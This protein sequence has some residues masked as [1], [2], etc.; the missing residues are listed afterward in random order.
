MKSNY[1]YQRID[2]I[3]V[4]MAQR[5][6]LL[7]IANVIHSSTDTKSH[8]ITNTM[9]LEEEPT[10]G[11][12]FP[13]NPETGGRIPTPSDAVFVCDSN[14]GGAYNPQNY[15]PPCP[16]GPYQNCEKGRKVECSNEH[17]EP[18]NCLFH[19]LFSCM[20]YACPDGKNF[21][22]KN[23]N[24]DFECAGESFECKKDF[25]CTSMHVY[26]CN[27]K[28][29][30]SD[31]FE[32]EGG[33]ECISPNTCNSTYP[34]GNVGGNQGLPGPFPDVF[35]NPGDFMCGFSMGT[36]SVAFLC[37]TSFSCQ[38]KQGSD[39]VC[40]DGTNFIC[41]ETGKGGIFKCDLIHEKTGDG[42]SCFQGEYACNGSTVVCDVNGHTD[43][44]CVFQNTVYATC[45]QSPKE[46]HPSNSHTPPPPSCDPFLGQH[47][48]S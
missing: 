33:K 36:P 13:K 45:P 11:L 34:Y 22:C 3:L 35:G 18:F 28:H 16:A 8:I 26:L 44:G 38:G 32:C 15:D 46:C 21:E 19:S 12:C 4:R 20:G 30:C 23:D 31:K 1:S 40:A 41:G 17:D 37:T 25:K 42:F 5:H 6:N 29:S 14:E 43:Y 24:T 48:G 27:H 7:D 9:V 39:F 10:R 2:A 47:G